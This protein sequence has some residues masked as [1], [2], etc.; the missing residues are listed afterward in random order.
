MAVRSLRLAKA[1]R[2][3]CR[4][5][6]I[7]FQSDPAPQLQIRRETAKALRAH[8]GILPEEELVKDVEGA[9]EMVRYQIVQAQ[10]IE[11]KEARVRITQDHIQYGKVIDLNEPPDLAKP[12]PD[13]L[14]GV[15]RT[16]K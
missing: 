12:I 4:A 5:C 14:P 8:V 6:A 16:K 2:D 3:L 13:E 7:T 11:N 10:P 1:Y 9:A 15:G